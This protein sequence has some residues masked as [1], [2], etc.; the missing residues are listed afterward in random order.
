MNIVKVSDGKY[1]NVDRV[2]F[3]EP[4]RRGQLVVHFSVAGGDWVDSSCTLK[5]E[6]EEAAI[7]LRWLDG[8]S[9]DVRP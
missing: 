4:K 5:L 6:Q 2:T 9:Q 8:H 1:I 3:V 7:F